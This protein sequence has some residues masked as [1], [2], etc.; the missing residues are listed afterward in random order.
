VFRSHVLFISPLKVLDLSTINGGGLIRQDSSNCHA[1][2]I[3]EFRL[4]VLT[5]D[6]PTEDA[7]LVVFNTLIPQDDPSNSRRF[8]VPSGSYDWGARIHLDCD[9]HLGTP[10][11][12]E[13][14]V[15][16]PAQA[17]FV[18]ELLS[19]RY[20]SILAVVRTQALIEYA[21]SPHADSHVPWD[22]WGEGAMV[23]EVPGHCDDTST[24]VHGTKIVVQTSTA[25]RPGYPPSYRV[26][27]FDF[28]RRE[29]SSPQ[30]LN[31]EGGGTERGALFKDGR[32]FKVEGSE[33]MSPW[34][35]L[36]SLGDGSLFYLVSYLYRSIGS[37][38]TG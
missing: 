9:R 25:A 8:S 24:F 18:V 21:R 23:L 14:L 38:I 4:M 11:M 20:F 19:S 26:H 17:I 10:D 33:G 1:D 12:D 16:D 30:L 28:S 29:R 3:D 15:A 37:K 6:N 34:A 13:P 35:S 27:T 32:S 2:F 31:E 7:E 5:H 22:E 36:Q